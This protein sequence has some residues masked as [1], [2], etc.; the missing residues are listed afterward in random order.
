MTPTTHHS[1][2]F[3]FTAPTGQ[4]EICDTIRATVGVRELEGL[5]KINVIQTFWLPDAEELELLKQ[6]HPVVLEF[7]GAG[8]PMHFAG[9]AQTKEKANDYRQ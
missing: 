2:N 4:E 1:N 8:C 7:L 9:V 3:T 6:G 5:D